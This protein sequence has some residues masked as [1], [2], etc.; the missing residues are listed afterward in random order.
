M[1]SFSF[2]EHFSPKQEKKIF[3]Y[4]F[5][6]AVVY[7]RLIKLVRMNTFEKQNVKLIL[8]ISKRLLEI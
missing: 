1:F 7:K 8:S 2:T 5:V 6:N 3:P 4:H